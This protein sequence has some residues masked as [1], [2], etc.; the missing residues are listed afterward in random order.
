[1]ERQPIKRHEAIV[2]FSREHHFG[3]LLCWKIRHGIRHQIAPERIAP[4]V[5]HFFDADL[6]AHFD[7]EEKLLFDKLPD[8]P[9]IIQAVGEHGE[10]YALINRISSGDKGYEVLNHFADKL[11]AHIRF[12]ERTLFNHLQSI[13]SEAELMEVSHHNEAKTCD[14]DEGWSDHFW[15]IK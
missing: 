6:K 12:E 2:T 15:K 7:K 13:L 10:I 3:L 4:Y 1:V 9:L 14:I 5:L 11:D 8:D